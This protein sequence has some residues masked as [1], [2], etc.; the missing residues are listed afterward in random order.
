M[1]TLLYDIRNL[2]KSVPAPEGPVEILRGVNLEIPHGCTAAIVGASG[3]GKST[4]LHLV[5]SLDTPTQGNILFEGRDFADLSAVEKSTLRNRRI[6]FI[7]QAHHLLPEFTALENTAM[8]AIIAGMRREQAAELAAKA[9]ALVDM[10]HKTGQNVTTLSGGERQRVGIARAILHEPAVL[11]ADEPTGNLD[12]KNGDLVG[13]ML[14]DL[15]QK[16]GMAILV[17]THNRDLADCMSRTMELR[18]GELYA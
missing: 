13:R 9:L 8:P 11:L 12:Q 15:N 14:A 7:F 4:L 17:V 3:S 2:G 18:D 5:G 10:E 16:L 1:S 6:G